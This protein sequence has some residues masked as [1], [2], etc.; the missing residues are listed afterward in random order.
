[1]TTPPV[2]ELVVAKLDLGW[3]HTVVPGQGAVTRHPVDPDTRRQ[4]EVQVPVES[5]SLRLRHRDGRAAAAVW[6]AEWAPDA[7]AERKATKRD[8]AR[9]VLVV[10]HW[11]YRFDQ[12]FTW[13]ACLAEACRRRGAEHASGIPTL[14]GAAAF[15]AWLA[16]AVTTLPAPVAADTERAAA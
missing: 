15:G 2:V 4:V 3:R 5:V 7:W 13:E 1:M 9:S 8:G 14:L 16:P 6:V 12:A 11:H 10:A